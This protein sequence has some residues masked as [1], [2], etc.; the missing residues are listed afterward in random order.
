M[1]AILSLLILAMTGV[2]LVWNRTMDACFTPSNILE[3][4][5]ELSKITHRIRAIPNCAES[6]ANTGAT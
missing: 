5:F 6:F 3:T 4:S 2:L 1:E